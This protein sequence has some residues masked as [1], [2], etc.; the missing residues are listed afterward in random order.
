[1]GAAKNVTCKRC[2]YKHL[3]VSHETTAFRCSSCGSSLVRA[4]PKAKK[5]AKKEKHGSN[6]ARE[7]IIDESHHSSMN[8]NKPYSSDTGLTVGAIMTLVLTYVMMTLETI[9]KMTIIG[10]VYTVYGVSFVCKEL[11][12]NG[13]EVAGCFMVIVFI[14]L[15]VG[16]V[17]FGVV[18]SSESNLIM[19]NTVSPINGN[20]SYMT[21]GKPSDMSDEEW[22]WTRERFKK[23]GLNDKDADEAARAAWKFHQQ[24]KGR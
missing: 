11:S 9:V 22:K 14:V 18:I 20:P 17:Y 8:E 16:I 2:G 1:M 23:E 12:K 6:S 15:L 19:P 3:F 24:Q 4:L 5:E 21:N 7:K 13:S 10:F